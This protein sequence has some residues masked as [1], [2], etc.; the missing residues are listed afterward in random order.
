[1]KILKT[2]VGSD[3]GK[4][5]TI[6][7]ISFRGGLWIVPLWN[8]AQDGKW[9]QPARIIRIDVLRH[10]RMPQKIGPHDIVLNEPVPKRLLDGL[11][12]QPEDKH[13]QI[14]D[15]PDAPRIR[16]PDTLH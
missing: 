15:Q 1:M 8:E 5:Y 3:D 13:F 9:I 2:A 14:E 6:D 7:T 16:S 11:P 12:P 4:I 10:Q